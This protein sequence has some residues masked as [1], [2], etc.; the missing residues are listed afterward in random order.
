VISTTNKLTG[1]NHT[2]L[3]VAQLRQ[4]MYLLQLQTEEGVQSMKFIKN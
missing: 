2:E 3:N 1:K 4:G